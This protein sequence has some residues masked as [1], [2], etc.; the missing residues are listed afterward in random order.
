MLKR[1]E[2]ALLNLINKWNI[3]EAQPYSSNP[4]HDEGMDLGREFCAD[5]LAY[6]IKQM[7]K[8]KNK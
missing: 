2:K 1:E 6:V 7:K 5:E 3:S 4:E 8:K